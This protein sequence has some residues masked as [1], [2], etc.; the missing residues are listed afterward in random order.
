MRFKFFIFAPFLPHKIGV[1]PGKWLIY[2]IFLHK[3]KRVMGLVQ[4]YNSVKKRIKSR[5][6]RLS[7][8]K[9][10]YKS[11]FICPLFA[12]FSTQKNRLELTGRVFYSSYL[13]FLMVSVSPTMSSSMLLSSGVTPKT[14]IISAGTVNLYINAFLLAVPPD[15]QTVIFFTIYSPISQSGNCILL[16]GLPLLPIRSLLS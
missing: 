6:F 8:S 9:S 11:L 3:N 12:P 7:M 2:G 16:P 10:V 14:F 5:L 13:L 1:L 4:M 15:L